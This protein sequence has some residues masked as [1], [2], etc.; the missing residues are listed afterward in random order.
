MKLA[1]LVD[2]NRVF[3]G[4]PSGDRREVYE[5]ILAKL[6]QTVPEQLDQTATI[7]N[8]I[9]REDSTRLPYD[10]GLAI[11]HVRSDEFT[12]YHF[13]ITTLDKP[14]K[15]REWDQ[16]PC[17]VV[18]MSLIPPAASDLYLKVLAAVARYVMCSGNVEK[19]AAA[20]SAEA[21]LKIIADDNITIKSTLTAEDIMNTQ[22]TTVSADSDV[23]LAIDVMTRDRLDYL[24]VVNNAGTMVGVIGGIDIISKAVPEYLMMMDNINF[25]TSFEPFEKVLRDEASVKVS[26]LMRPID[27][28]V[29]PAKLPI[30]QFTL[31]LVKGESEQFFVVDE[32]GGFIGVVGI[33]EIIKKILRG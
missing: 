25:L 2:V 24:P 29:I 16:Q 14:V 28:I 5:N 27:D 19:L 18:L 30:I 33:Q 1:S 13:A 26:E 6:L 31:R 9:E 7:E 3:V 20:P 8:M 32:N 4:E 17:R 23:A 22:V 21:L 15:L 10:G 11:P 12:D